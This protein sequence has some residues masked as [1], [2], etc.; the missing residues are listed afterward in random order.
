MREWIN[1]AEKIRGVQKTKASDATKVGTVNVL[2]V[3]GLF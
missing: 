1:R 2:W 3:V